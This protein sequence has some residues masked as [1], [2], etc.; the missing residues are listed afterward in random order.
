M[1]NYPKKTIDPT[2]A[3]LV[4]AARK[5]GLAEGQLRARLPRIGEVPFSSERKTKRG[6]R[7]VAR[8]CS[9]TSSVARQCR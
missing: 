1:A 5:A 7:P 9:A 6:S 3:A 8:S 2:E 4:V